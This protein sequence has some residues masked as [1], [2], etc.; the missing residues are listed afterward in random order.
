MPFIEDYDYSSL[1]KAINDKDLINL[2]DLVGNLY[3]NGDI[4]KNKVSLPRNT[5]GMSPGD[6]VTVII[7]LLQALKGK[8]SCKILDFWVS[9]KRIGDYGQI[10]QCKQL[11][12][13]LF[14]TD[15]MQLL[16]SL[17]VKSS[18]VWSPDF[19]KVLWYNSDN[20]SIMCNGYSSLESKLTCSK[21]RIERKKVVY[22]GSVWTIEKYI[23]KDDEGVLTKMYMIKKG[24][25]MKKVTPDEIQAYD[26]NYELE[27]QGFIKPLTSVADTLLK[28]TV[29]KDTQILEGLKPIPNIRGD[30]ITPI[31]F[32]VEMNEA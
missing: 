23:I 28:N 15:S 29:D 26:I 5:K 20:D 30:I 27:K 22:E 13:P 24:D 32:E 18:V 7:G 10:L 2:K 4:N 16:I 25:N 21:K 12:I 9:L 11:G 3:F 8:L 6:I 14:T 19:T 31:T 1:N 17:A